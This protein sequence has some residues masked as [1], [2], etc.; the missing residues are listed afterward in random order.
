MAPRTGYSQQQDSFSGTDQFS[1]V[2]AISCHS[3]KSHSHSS[4]LKNTMAQFNVGIE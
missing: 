3:R 4:Y 1:E 2:L